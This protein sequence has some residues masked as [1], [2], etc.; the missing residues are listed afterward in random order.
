MTVLAF[1]EMEDH[2][3]ALD[4]ARMVPRKMPYKLASHQVRVSNLVMY[5]TSQCMQGQGDHVIRYELVY[6]PG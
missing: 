3:V 4:M 6:S 5:N 2:E 1:V